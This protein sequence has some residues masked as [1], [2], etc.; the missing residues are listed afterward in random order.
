MTPQE[1]YRAAQQSEP[2][3]SERAFEPRTRGPYTFNYATPQWYSFTMAVAKGWS[4]EPPTE[5]RSTANSP[6]DVTAARMV[7]ASAQSRQQSFSS[8]YDWI[9]E[10][11]VDGWGVIMTTETGSESIVKTKRAA[12][13]EQLTKG[14]ASNYVLSEPRGG[15]SDV[16]GY[17]S[18]WTF[19]LF[20]VVGLVGAFL[21]ME[22]VK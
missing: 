22:V 17:S 6:S 1:A 4:V 7:P 19:P 2:S 9:K 14:S 12:V 15:W 11:Q 3:L 20:A 10:A 5:M 8:A 18:P 16:V 13:A 21:L